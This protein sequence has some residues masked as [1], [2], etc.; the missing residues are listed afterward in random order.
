M[1]SKHIRLTSAEVTSLWTSYMNESA[2]KCKYM[3]LLSKVKDEEIRPLVQQALDITQGNLTT[4]KEIFNNEK[5]P[6]PHGFSSNQDVDVSAPSLYSDLYVLNYLH[7]AAQIALQGYSLNL[8]LAVRKDVYSYFNECI[9]QLT[10]FLREVKELLLSEGLYIKSPFLPMP[11]NIDFVKRQSFLTGFLGEKR[12]L[13]GIEITNLYNNFQRNA[14]G[15]ATL[16]GFSQVAQSK[17]VVNFLVRGKEIA[18]KHCEYFGLVLAEDDIPVPSTWD[19]EVTESTVPTFSEKL[20][21]FYTT[22]LIAL[23]VGYYGASM[24]MSPRRDLG[25]LYG[26]L[27]A[28][29]LIYAE[30]GANIMIKNGWLEQPPKAPDRDELIKKD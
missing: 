5:Y 24:G 27:S 20:M 14:F 22:G 11:D 10:T 9:A 26:R 28:E 2:I 23:S 17:E 8:S 25:V 6:I 18:K 4:L 19:T 21:M 13:L 16:I 15:V 29:I 12:P 30:D 3:Y 7:M 1:G